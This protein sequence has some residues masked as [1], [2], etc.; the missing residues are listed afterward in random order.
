VAKKAKSKRRHLRAFSSRLCNLS[1]AS[2]ITAL[3]KFVKLLIQVVT[4]WN[5]LRGQG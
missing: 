3:T 5:L 2:T 1:K 4:L